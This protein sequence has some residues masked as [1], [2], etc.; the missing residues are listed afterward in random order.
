MMATLL[1]LF[2]KEEAFVLAESDRLNN[3]EEIELSGAVRVRFKVKFIEITEDGYRVLMPFVNIVWKDLK[4]RRLLKGHVL[5]S[6]LRT[7]DEK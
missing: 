2:E 6:C 4:Q 1:L 5:T 3:G 7:V